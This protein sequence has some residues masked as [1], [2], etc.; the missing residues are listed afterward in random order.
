[1]WKKKK[2]KNGGASRGKRKERTENEDLTGNGTS[3]GGQAERGEMR[4]PSGPTSS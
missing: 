2:L 3:G 4:R 1:M